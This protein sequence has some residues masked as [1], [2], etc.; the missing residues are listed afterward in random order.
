MI[1]P[2]SR[3]KIQLSNPTDTHKK[4]RSIITSTFWQA[5]SLVHKCA[6]LI[7]HAYLT[8]SQMDRTSLLISQWQYYPMQYSRTHK[9]MVQPTLGGPLDMMPEPVQPGLNKQ[10]SFEPITVLLQDK[11]EYLAK[12]FRRRIEL[13]QLFMTRVLV[14][15]WCYQWPQSDLTVYW[16]CLE[17]GRLLR[18]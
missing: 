15:G 12:H 5:P 7:C 18:P 9:H 8:S 1:S 6:T 3:S 17:P 13:C 10:Y 11:R 16:I 14:I 2:C 4:W